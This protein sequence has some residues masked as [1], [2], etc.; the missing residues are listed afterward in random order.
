MK[1]YLPKKLLP[2][3][4]PSLQGRAIRIGK[5]GCSEL[6]CQPLTRQPVNPRFTDAVRHYGPVTFFH[7]SRYRKQV[8][9]GNY[10]VSH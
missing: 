8:Y 9:R 4:S 6:T 7:A 10:D 1:L 2:S 5:R 3:T